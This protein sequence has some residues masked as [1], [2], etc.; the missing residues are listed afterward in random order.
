MLY[1]N[2]GSFVDVINHP[3]WL[4]MDIL[5]L[6]QHPSILNTVHFQ[7]HDLRQGLPQFQNDSVDIIR[8]SHV[9]EHLSLEDAKQLMLE[10]YR[11]LKVNGVLRV[12]VPDID[13]MIR[14]YIADGMDWYNG[15]QPDEF[16]NAPTQGEKLS[17]LIFSGDYSHRAV[18]SP[19]MMWHMISKAGFDASVMLPGWSHSPIIE[20][21]TQD[22][23][24][25]E[26]FVMEGVKYE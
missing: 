16:I 8:A 21:D 10:C 3:F 6:Q 19:E 13:T 4:N 24:V 15:V 18:Y 2:L 14:Q 23:H 20:R 1:L 9:I 7:Q 12:S 17:R 11:V 26:S 22:Q 5:P 25:R